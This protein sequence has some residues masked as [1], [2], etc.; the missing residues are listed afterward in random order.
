VQAG[1]RSE[2]D[3]VVRVAVTGLA[4]GAQVLAGS[5]GVVREGVQ[6]KT[7]ATAR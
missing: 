7:A 1:A 5:V 6:V 4:E 2:S 3:G